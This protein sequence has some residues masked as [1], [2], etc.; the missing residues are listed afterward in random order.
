MASQYAVTQDALTRFSRTAQDRADRLRRI[1]EALGAHSPGA[2]AFGK[3]PESEETGQD[4]RERVDATLENLDFA[5]G[6]QE[7]IAE[8]IERTGR[9]YQEVED[10][11]VD[12]VRSIAAQARGAM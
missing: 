2:N 9:S 4:Y 1:R 8:F 5:A 10:H 12:Q 11:T 3:L 6:Q 7:Q